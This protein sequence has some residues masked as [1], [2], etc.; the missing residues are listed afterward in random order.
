M[1]FYGTYEH[2]IDERGRLAVPARYRRALQEG[3]VLRA[4]ADGC[5][6]LYSA[7]GFQQ[8]VELRLGEQRSNR[9][10]AGR[11]IRRAFLPGAFDIELDRQ[12]RVLVPQSLRAE[13]ALGDRAVIVGCGDYVE[14]WSP[15]RWTAESEAVQAEQAGRGRRIVSAATQPTHEPVMLREVVEGLAVRPGGRYIDA[16]IGLGGHAQAILRAASPGG[17]LMGLDRDAEA[18]ALAR[19]RLTRFGDAVVLV[20]GNFSALGEL[21]P[22]HGFAAVDGVL[23]DLGVSSLQLEA[24]GRG[25][26][27][28]RDEPLDMRMDRSAQSGDVT[29]AELVNGLN[30][31]ELAELIREHG[32]ERRAGRIARTIVERRPVRSTGD[33]VNGRRAGRGK[34]PEASNPPATLTFQALR[35][36]VNQ[37][38][39]HLVLAL[40]AAAACSPAL[41]PGSS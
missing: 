17:S 10:V 6:E 24:R 26:S 19:E 16:T 32:E 7:D 11:R 30:E 29:A 2:S 18:L 12:G 4:G 27:F 22:A 35:I 33:L 23:L 14:I 25:F 13:A 34:G 40:P 1:T 9:E 5:L 41:A 36:A 15:E 31:G 39:E 37:E 8:E 20:H 28:Q 3:T 38:T 21:A